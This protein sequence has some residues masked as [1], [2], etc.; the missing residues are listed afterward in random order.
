MLIARRIHGSNLVHQVV[1]A[2]SILNIGAQAFLWIAFARDLLA[3][4]WPVGLWALFGLGGMLSIIT[5]W[6]QLEQWYRPQPDAEPGQKRR[7]TSIDQ[8]ALIGAIVSVGGNM[9]DLGVM[10]WVGVPLRPINYTLGAISFGILVFLVLLARVMP[11][12]NTLPGVARYKAILAFS[13]R[14]VIQSCMGVIAFANHT[15][16]LGMLPLFALSLI[17][18]TFWAMFGIQVLDEPTVPSRATFY[19]WSA[20]LVSIVVLW[21]AFLRASIP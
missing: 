13:T 3:H 11:W 1:L 8:M 20:N 21:A 15:Q 7:H 19:V 16:P 10:G 14:T 2:G 6:F 18:L 9:I 12:L 17:G 5:L 4:N